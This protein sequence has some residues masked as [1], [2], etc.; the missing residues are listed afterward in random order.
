MSFPIDTTI[1]NAPNFP[2]NDQPKMKTNFTNISGYLSVDHVA[3]GSTGAGKHKFVEILNVAAPG[4]QTNP[5]SIIYTLTGTK[6]TVSEATFKNSR[7]VFPLS[8]IRAFVNYTRAGSV[9]N[10]SYNVTSVVSGVNDVITFTANAMNGN[11]VCFLIT[12]S[13]PGPNSSI[14]YT[15]ANPVLTLSF[16]GSGNATINIL[17][18]QF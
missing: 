5:Q 18:L 7:G 9:I 4:A 10:N 17:A 6:S 12:G 14:Q 1:P 2:G 15:F 8:A 3:P 13:N 16:I 11:S